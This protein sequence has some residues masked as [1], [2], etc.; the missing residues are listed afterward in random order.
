VSAGHARRSALDD[1][2]AANPSAAN[3]IATLFM[4]RPR[5]STLH[6]SPKRS[7]NT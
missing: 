6:G 3:S 4:V 7:A 2:T 5:A 1:T